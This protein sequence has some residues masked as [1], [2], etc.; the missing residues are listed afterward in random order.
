MK[1]QYLPLDKSSSL[2]LAASAKAGKR[3]MMSHVNSR[4]NVTLH[5]GRLDL[6]WTRATV[7]FSKPIK[8]LYLFD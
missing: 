7:S 4:K 6:G 8:C 3:A 5:K 2:F 1:E